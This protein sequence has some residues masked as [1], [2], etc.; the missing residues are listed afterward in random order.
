MICSFIKLSFLIRIWTK[1]SFLV[2]MLIVVFK[3]LLIFLFY[4]L[5]VIGG[6][7][8]M[9]QIIIKESGD[10]YDGIKTAAF[11]VIV[12]RQSIGDYDTSSIIEGTQDFKILAWLLWFLILIIGNIVFMNFIIAVVSESYENCMQQKIQLIYSAKLEMI[13]ECEDL[14]PEWL[15]VTKRDWFPR[16]IIIRRQQGSG[17][18]GGDDPEEWQG[19]VKQVKRHLEHEN[20]KLHEIFIQIVNRSTDSTKKEM[21]TGLEEVK[22]DTATGL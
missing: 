2:R 12:L 16:F 1:V 22:K 20:S 19:F 11:F 21:K 9:A 3:E 18:A 6:L 17:G 7:T 10:G 8:V 15:F 5:L 4:F 13:E 14:M